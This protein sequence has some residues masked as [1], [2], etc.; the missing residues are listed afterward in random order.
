MTAVA[1]VNVACTMTGPTLF[2]STWLIVTERRVRPS[3]LAAST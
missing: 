2:G 1:S 3:A